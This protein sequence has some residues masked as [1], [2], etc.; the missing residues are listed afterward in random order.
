VAKLTSLHKF[1]KK[2][3]LRLKAS[4]FKTDLICE[5]S[6]AIYDGICTVTYG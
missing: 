4:T 1:K 5:V 2:K 6:D 3:L